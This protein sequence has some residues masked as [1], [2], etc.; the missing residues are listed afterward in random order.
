MTMPTVEVLYERANI[1]LDHVTDK[2]ISAIREVILK[3]GPM[4]AARVRAKL[5][6][7][8][9]KIRSG[10]LLSSIHNEMVESADSLYGRVYSTGVPYARIHEYGGTTS[11]HDIFPRNA[12]ALRFLMGGRVVFSRHVHHPGSVIPE[13]SYLRS[14]LTEMYDQIQNDMKEA[15]KRSLRDAA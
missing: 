6:G 5:S 2:V 4:L 13:R 14:S 8:V 12:K 1:K 3:D 7:E 11:P 15:M 10:K 9:L